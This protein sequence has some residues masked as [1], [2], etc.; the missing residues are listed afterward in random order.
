MSH[1]YKS[2][3]HMHIVFHS[4]KHISLF[5]EEEGPQ[6]RLLLF[7]T[8]NHRARMSHTPVVLDQFLD[9]DDEP[10]ACVVE[11][12]LR[13]LGCVHPAAGNGELLH[14]LEDLLKHLTRQ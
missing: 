11:L 4:K 5:R 12:V 8:Q 2:S 7:P 13:D 10:I 3:G 14:A 1:F 6:R 9:V